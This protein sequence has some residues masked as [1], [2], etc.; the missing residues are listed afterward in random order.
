MKLKNNFDLISES[1]KSFTKEIGQDEA[2]DLE[3]EAFL[4][5]QAQEE[6]MEAKENAQDDS[7]ELE[8]EQALEEKLT[9]EARE[10]TEANEEFMMERQNEVFKHGELDRN[11]L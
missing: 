3:T 2:V 5:D 6:R 9:A 4:E 8:I 7:T 1:V 11:S 10:Q